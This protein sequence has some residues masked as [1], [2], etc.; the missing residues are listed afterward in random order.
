MPSAPFVVY[1]KTGEWS[2][3]GEFLG[4]GRI[5]GKNKVFM[6]YCEAKKMVS[7]IGLKKYV[8]W[9][10]YIKLNGLIDGVPRHPQR[11]YKD[12]GWVSWGEFL[13]SK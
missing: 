7:N 4:T 8:D 12:D 9:E 10:V 3:W 5:H 1:K 2:S 6:K 13:G 11:Y